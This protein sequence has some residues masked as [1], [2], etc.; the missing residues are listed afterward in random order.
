MDNSPSSSNN[1]QQE[2]TGFSQLQRLLLITYA[3]GFASQATF[4]RLLDR[5]FLDRTKVQLG[6]ILPRDIFFTFCGPLS[7]V[8]VISQYLYKKLITV[9]VL[10]HLYDFYPLVVKNHKLVNKNRTRA[11]TMN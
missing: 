9:M 1:K 5:C 8:H 3:D 4:S 2:E 7:T 6:L 11:P 10:V